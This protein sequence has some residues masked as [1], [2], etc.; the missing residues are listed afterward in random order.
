MKRQALGRG[1]G[2][3]LPDR[4]PA[5]PVADT[6]LQIE[7]ER[8]VPNP[9]QPRETFDE[10][11]LEDLSE[12]IRRAGILQPI[13]VRETEIGFELVAGERRLRAAR[14]AGLASVPA[15]VQQIDKGRSLEYALIENIQ[16][17][18][19]N[20][21]EESRA[22]ATLITEYNLTQDEVAQRVGRKRSSIANSLRL[23][24]LPQRVQEMLRAGTLTAGHAKALLSLVDDEEI[25][26][27]ADAM[28]QGYVTVRGAEEMAR[29]SKSQPASE[30][31]TTPVDPNV[32]DAEVRLQR[33]LGTKVR[34]R[35][36]ASGKGRIEI[37]F[38][39]G[40]EL[41]RLF[42]LLERHH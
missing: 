18:Q 16:R 30:R 24:K 1:L 36:A 25:L 27:A 10:S 23:L 37:E 9:R 34:I 33:A 26:K 35:Q 19:L 40:E 5:N 21:M 12:S 17:Q 22:F 3:L 38:F 29:A 32:R 8:I 31:D 15:M 6:F 7:V 28:L 13:L 14:M 11:E 20:P 42:E 41:Q 39:D 4:R 2:A